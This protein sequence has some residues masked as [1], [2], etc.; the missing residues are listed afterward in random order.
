MNQNRYDSSIYSQLKG[1]YALFREIVEGLGDMVYVKDLKGHYLS[2]NRSFAERIERTKEEIIGN[3]DT[4][5]LGKRIATQVAFHEQLLLHIGTSVEY[6]LEYDGGSKPAL[7]RCKKYLLRDE[8]G[9]PTAIVGI[10]RDVTVERLAENKYRFLFD[11]APIAFW[12]EDFS[13]V[14]RVLTELRNGGV[15]DFRK[16]FQK[17]PRDVE[18]CIAAIRIVDVNLATLRMNRTMDKPRIIADLKRRLTEDTNALF[19]EEFTALAEGRTFYQSEASTIDVGEDRLDVLFNLNVLPGHESDLSLVLISVIDV[20]QVKRA[21]LQLNELKELY[22]GVVEGQREMICRFLPGGKLTF[23]NGAFE[24]FFGKKLNSAP[25]LTFHQLLFPDGDSSGCP[26][27][28]GNLTPENPISTVELRNYDPAGEMVWQQWSVRALFTASGKATQYQAVGSDITDRK[29]TEERLAAS[30]ARWRAVF[31]NAEDIIMMMNADGLILSANR[32]ANEANGELLAGNLLADVLNKENTEHTAHALKRVFEAG[33]RV[34]MELKLMRGKLK[35]HVLNCVFTPMFQGD[36]VLSATLIARDVTESRRL[37]HLVREALI[38]GQEQ[39]RKRVSRELHDGL[40]QLFTAIK[41]N[42]Q[43]LRS[44][45]GPQ[46]SGVSLERLEIL[47]KNI[48]VAINEVKHIS[49]NLMPEVLELYGLSPALHDLVNNWNR[50]EGRVTITLG[51]VGLDHEPSSHISLAIFRMAQ[52]LITN[53]VRHGKASAI[54]VQVIDHGASIMLVVE[55]DGLGFDPSKG[56]GGLGLRN[57]RSRAELLEGRVDIDSNPG[58][59]TVT[60]IEIP[61]RP[62]AR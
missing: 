24:T 31:E 39:E 28:L 32:P 53:A 9:R 4:E 55:D 40:G 51:T 13:D 1:E 58:K 36:R 16:H 30:E 61:Y 6:E 38:E 56:S 27:H 7:F 2:V 15:K 43:H 59:G 14:N 34:E 35:G 42:M 26:G 23:Y 50:S 12:E 45:L 25:D 29:I 17:H 8:G 47:E 62:T 54:F 57:I 33:D 52:E 44:G 11:N 3:S 46:A 18:R 48:T 60:T 22:R 37:E 19:I 41:M 5:L 10:S 21:E 20:T 49:H